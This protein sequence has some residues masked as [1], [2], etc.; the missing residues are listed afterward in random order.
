MIEIALVVSAYLLGSVPS[1]YILG[2]MAG[3]DIRKAGSGNV[4]ATNVTR[5][6]GKGRGVLTL[7]GDVAKGW[8]PVFAGLQLEMS[9]TAV[10]LAG[11]AAFLG[12]LYPVFLRFE[13]E[14]AWPRRWESLLALAP[15][16]TLVFSS[17]LPYGGC[18]PDRFPW[19]HCRGDCGAG[20]SLDRRLSAHRVAMGGFLCGDDH[21]APPRQHPALAC[22]HRATFWCRLIFYNHFDA[23]ILLA[24]AFVV[25]GCHRC[26]GAETLREIFRP[27]TPFRSK[28]SA[29]VPAR[30]SD[31]RWL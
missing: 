13:E 19:F 21:Q 12:H 7:V 28:S 5:L 8:L 22:R 29:T 25:V 30:R 15:M 9:L 4:G 16:A 26:A 17:F 27:L 6:L 31:R 23:A 2:N 1:G 14:K 20:K 11:A 24:S 10:T 18:D 3:V